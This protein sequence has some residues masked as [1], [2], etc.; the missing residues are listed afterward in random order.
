MMYRQT[1]LFTLEQIIELQ[2]LTKLQAALTF[3][4]YSIL[5]E[6][7]KID[8]GKRGPKG[9]AVTSLLNSLLAMQLEQL[10]TIKSLVKRL[11]T[12]P[13]FRIACGFEAVSKTPSAATFSRFIEK[14]SRTDVLEKT[15]QRMIRKAKSLGLV[16]GIHV[17]IDASKIDAFEH[18]VP[19]AKIPENNPEFPHWGAKNDTN[20]N[21]IKWFG[22]KMHALVDTASGIPLAYIITPANVADMDMA[23]PLMQKLKED[24]NQLFKPSYYIMDTGYDKPLIYKE[25]LETFGGQAIIPINWRNTKIPPEGINWD[26]QLVC[27]MNHPYVYGG[28]DKGTIRLLCPHECGKVS[29]S[30]GSHWCTNAKSGYV[31]KVRVKDNPRFISAPMRGS[32][33]WQNLYNERS[34]VERFFGEAK[35]NYSL[36]NL[37]VSGIKKA[38]VF[39]DL[40]CIAVIISRLSKEKPVKNTAA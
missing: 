34:S 23:L 21:M 28:N 1:M 32:A 22:W 16:E 27:S 31:G 3:V 17:S 4:D 12:D 25:A 8:D 14:L 18:A 10:P 2:P 7:F 29:C 37:R 35:E 24:Y 5:N 19:K 9:F 39:M 30:M 20:G 40:S 13:V 15:F 38:K 11:K 26:G 6:H 36:N 33:A